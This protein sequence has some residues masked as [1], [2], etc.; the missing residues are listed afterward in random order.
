MQA[1]YSSGSWTADDPYH[2]WTTEQMN[3]IGLH[4][5]DWDKHFKLMTDIE[6]N[7]YGATDFNVIWYYDTNHQKKN[8][9]E[10][11]AAT[12]DYLYIPAGVMAV[13]MGKHVNCNKP[14]GDRPRET[15]IRRPIWA[16]SWLGSRRIR[17]PPGKY[18]LIL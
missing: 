14:F 17:P 8:I 13:K 10:V 12:P 4:E 6:L 18:L 7:G 5:E 11:V 9:D 15:L 1:K 3:E 2:I 16:A